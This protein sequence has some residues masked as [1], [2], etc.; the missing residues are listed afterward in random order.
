MCYIIIALI[1]EEEKNRNLF[2]FCFLLPVALQKYPR[3][4]RGSPA[5][6]VASV[7]VARVQISSS[8]P[9]VNNANLEFNS[10]FVLFFDNEY[11]GIKIDR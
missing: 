7:M 6:G 5:K 8:A 9:D 1:K 3:G 10:E 2:G 4:S 11:F